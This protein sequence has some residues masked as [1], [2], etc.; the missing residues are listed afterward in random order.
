MVYI[1]KPNRVFKL[2]LLPNLEDSFFYFIFDICMLFCLKKKRNIN[3]HPP[4]PK[5]RKEY[6]SLEHLVLQIDF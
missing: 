3:L 6:K 2:V 4:P 5:N 1:D